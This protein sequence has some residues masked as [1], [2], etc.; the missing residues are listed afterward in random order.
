ML[1]C[2]ILCAM[3]YDLH[4]MYVLNIMQILFVTLCC[5]GNDD[6]KSVL[7]NPIDLSIFYLRLAESIDASPTDTDDQLCI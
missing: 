5:S 2:L 1:P 3:G 6:K 4:I 7:L